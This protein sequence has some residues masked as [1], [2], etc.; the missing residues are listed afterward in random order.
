[1]KLRY[2]RLA[3]DDLNTLFAFI[4]IEDALA[5]QKVAQSIRTAIERLI[6]FP[7]YGRVGDVDGTR[8]F[9]IAG[10]PYIVIYEIEGELVTILRIY[11]TAQDRPGTG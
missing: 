6:Q 5:A 3:L 10:L 4:E 8:Q 7:S 9:V 1:M 11:H 2:T